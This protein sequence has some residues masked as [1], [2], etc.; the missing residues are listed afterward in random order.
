[1]YLC[2]CPFL[3]YF[4]SNIT[5]LV[6]VLSQNNQQL[7]STVQTSKEEIVN[8][9]NGGNT[10][11]LGSLALLNASFT[12]TNNQTKQLTS[13]SQQLLQQSV[14]ANRGIERLTREIVGENRT[15]SFDEKRILAAGFNNSMH[16]M[17]MNIELA[18]EA[19]SNETKACGNRTRHHV[20]VSTRLNFSRTQRVL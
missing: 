20:N 15:F 10:A 14:V 4:F 2:P 19:V 1:M 16:A 12:T 3:P 13:Q 5:V 8:A 11:V 18:Y 7:I 9:T 17:V 6:D